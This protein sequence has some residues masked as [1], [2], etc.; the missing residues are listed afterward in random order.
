MGKDYWQELTGF[1]QKMADVG[2]ISCGDLDLIYVTDSVEEAIAQIRSKAI[3]SFGLKSVRRIKRSFPW[4]GERGLAE[5]RKTLAL[6]MK[7]HPH[8]HVE[9]Y[10]RCQLV[11]P[12][13]FPGAQTPLR[14]GAQ[15]CGR[16][17][18]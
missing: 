15:R 9:P 10:N 11:G 16:G 8:D 18:A 7:K 14:S 6:I 5:E 4:P 12:E 17:W 2:M 3:K 13:C 1:I